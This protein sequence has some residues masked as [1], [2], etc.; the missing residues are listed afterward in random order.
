[1][2]DEKK[3]EIVNGSGD[4]DISPVSEYI[5][6][7]KP[8]PKGKDEI[9]Y[10]KKKSIKKNTIFMVSFFLCYIAS[11][12]VSSTS[13]SLSSLL[14]ISKFDTETSYAI[15]FSTVPSSYFFSYSLD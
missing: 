13:F 12:F 15:L 7:E 5:E 1:M 8:K 4:L 2:S 9:V 14:F 10:L 3:I 6:I 11:W